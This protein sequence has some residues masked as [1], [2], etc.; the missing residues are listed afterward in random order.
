MKGRILLFAGMLLLT[1]PGY[2]QGGG[3]FTMLLTATYDYTTIEHSMGRMLAGGIDGVAT[4]TESTG[5]PVAKGT[6]LYM[7]CVVNGRRSGGDL[8]L[9]TS[10]VGTDT[11][12]DQARLYLSGGRRKGAAKEGGGGS[13]TVKIAGGAGRFAGLK[14]TCPYDTVYLKSNRLVTSANCAWE[15]VSGGGG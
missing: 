6:H 3:S 9:E 2:A 5:D 10:C 14:G 12:D 8:H 11:A 1:S 4:V 15:K 7:T 13:G